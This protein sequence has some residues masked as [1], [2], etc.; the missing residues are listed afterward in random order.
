MQVW[1]YGTASWMR[2]GRAYCKEVSLLHSS[3][4]QA[5]IAYTHELRHL[6]GSLVEQMSLDVPLVISFVSRQHSDKSEIVVTVPF[7]FDFSD[8][9]FEEVNY[10]RL[11]LRGDIGHGTIKAFIE[12]VKGSCSVQSDGWNRTGSSTWILGH[13]WYR[14]SGCFERWV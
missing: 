14:G 6:P 4:G 2:Q 13:A 9:I 5:Q 3:G 10:I 1:M 12:N 7:L 8:K 11:V